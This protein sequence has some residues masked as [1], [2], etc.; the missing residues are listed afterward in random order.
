M[1]VGG[2]AENPV[3][4]GYLCPKGR[5]MPQMHNDPDRILHAHRRNRTT[6]SSGFP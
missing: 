4:Q 6:G 1:R 2:D 3:Y 5:A